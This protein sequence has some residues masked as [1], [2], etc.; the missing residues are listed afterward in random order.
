MQT[1]PKVY[2]DTEFSIWSWTSAMVGDIDTLNSK[3]LICLVAGSQQKHEPPAA[4]D[5]Q[6]PPA[7]DDDH[8]RGGLVA[9]PPLSEGGRWLCCSIQVEEM[10]K[11][12]HVTDKQ[13]IEFIKW[14]IEVMMAGVH[15][16]VG[17]KGA[18]LSPERAARAGQ[19]L[20]GGWRCAYYGNQADCK[21]KVKQHMLSRHWQ[22]NFMCDR[23]LA[24][25]HIEAVN[26]YNF[27]PDAGW[28][29]LLV[30]HWMYLRSTDQDSLSPWAQVPG[31]RADRLLD[32]LLHNMWLGWGKDLVGQVLF[33]RACE[34]DDVEAGLADLSRKCKKW[35][36]DKKINTCFKPFTLATVGVSKAKDYPTLETKAKAAK[37]KLLFLW[38]C[39]TT[40]EDHTANNRGRHSA[41]RAEMLWRIQN[42]INVF[43]RSGFFLSAEDA[44]TVFA[45]GCK[46]LRLYTWFASEAL[47]AGVTAYKVHTQHTSTMTPHSKNDIAQPRPDLLNGLCRNVGQHMVVA[48]ND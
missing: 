30:D 11:V 1:F 33:E 43:D 19:P 12:P 20:A 41:I 40:I 18:P 14:N 31:W 25:R 24:A 29:S 34:Y 9:W 27:S 32:D 37:T 5:G 13:I 16:S 42:V 45:D 4:D 28:M 3:H 47:H 7:Y 2:K 46:F 8:S 17:F 36:S 6:K 26:P 44:E 38:L 10:R 48:E 39:S 23:C 15:P 21:E 22:C 35:F